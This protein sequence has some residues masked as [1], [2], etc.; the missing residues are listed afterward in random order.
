VES[1]ALLALCAVL[2]PSPLYAQSLR[3]QVIGTW[4]LVSWTRFVGDV[5]EPLSFGRDPVG[6]VMFAPDGHM[7]FNVMRRN[8]APFTSREFQAGTTDEKAFAYDGYLG[9]CGRY[10][11]DEQ[12][13]SVALRLDLSSYPNWTGTVQRRFVDV[14]GNRLRLRT[15]PISA[16]GKPVS[17]TVLWERVK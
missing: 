14:A 10:D 4:T 5:E 15:P 17:N 16:A 8:R 11:V 1:F 12:E 2:V 3:E 13:H 9:F 6:Q 7:C